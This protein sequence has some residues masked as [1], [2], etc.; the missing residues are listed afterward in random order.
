VANIINDVL[1]GFRYKY[2]ECQPLMD[3]CEGFKNILLGMT[4]NKLLMLALVYCPDQTLARD[5]TARS[6]KESRP[7]SEARPT[8]WRH[9]PTS[10][11]P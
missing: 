3:Y 10:S 7:I 4:E 9:V 11:S 1:F 8:F 5:W 2:E 6:W